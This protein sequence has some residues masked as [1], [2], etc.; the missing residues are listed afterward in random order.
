MWKWPMN[1]V[2]LAT[3]RLQRLNAGARR[4]LRSLSSRAQ[5]PGLSSYLPSI[6]P[7]FL[8]FLEDVTLPKSPTVP[9]IPGGLIPVDILP[10]S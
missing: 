9:E 7:P 3:T 5:P 6:V 1:R 10:I 4:L 8:C 2:E